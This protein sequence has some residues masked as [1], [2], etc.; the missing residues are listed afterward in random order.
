MKSMRKRPAGLMLVM[1]LAACMIM[2]GFRLQAAGVKTDRFITITLHAGENGYFE[3]EGVTEV[4]SVQ[5]RGDAF[6][7]RRQPSSTDPALLFA[8]WSKDPNADSPDVFDGMTNVSMIGTDLYAVW[9][10]DCIIN[11]VVSDGYIET[12]SGQYSV[13]SMTYEPGMNFRVLE[14]KH[15]DS[16]DFDFDGWYQNVGEGK[17]DWTEESIVQDAE[18]DLHARWKFAPDRTEY[19]E[20]NRKYDFELSGPGVIRAF[21]P[22]KNAVYEL[23]TENAEGGEGVIITVMQENCE[24]LIDSDFYDADGNAAVSLS[25]RAGVPYFFQIREMGGGYVNCTLSL[26]EV[27]SATVTFHAN[28]DEQQD[29]WFDDDPAMLEKKI[30]IAVGSDIA[31][32][33]MSGLT[34]K[35]AQQVGLAG[36]SAVPDAKSVPGELIV[37]G[38]MD[39][40]AV[41]SDLGVLILDANGGFFAFEGNS[42][43][44]R[45]RFIPGTPF[46]PT[47]DPRNDDNTV[48]FSGWS[49]DPDAKE[50]DADIIEGVTRCDDLGDRLYAVYGEK[51][52]ETF[53]ANGGYMLDDPSVTKYYSTKGKGHIF[54]GMVVHHENERMKAIGFVD[55]DG[56]EIPYTADIYPYYH[57]N[58]DTVYTTVWGYTVY[59]DANGGYFP[60]AEAEKLKVLLPYEDPFDLEAI[61]DQIGEPV[62]DDPDKV[63]AGWATDP[64]ADTPDIVS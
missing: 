42:E 40:Y 1:L 31:Q 60:E 17:A 37:K 13:V 26:R 36:W 30:P 5:F 64:Y 44:M 19:I 22:Q 9:R 32:Y 15:Y 12:D 55:Q 54:Y 45:H 38:D 24:K 46:E 4:E 16:Q 57:V 41:T 21:M 10:K 39:V 43:T 47:Y 48:K 14:A 62:N 25:M 29:A 11:Y 56:T 50:P 61:L 33:S 35:D 63:F 53:D 51:V 23:R 34:F 20:R 49:R 6:Y 52:L 3:E 8:G 7:E 59:V 58:G 27:K 28:R 2:P 18:I